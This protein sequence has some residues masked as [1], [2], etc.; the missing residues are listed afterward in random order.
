[1]DLQAIVDT[2]QCICYIAK[3]ATKGEPTSQQATEILQSA[4]NKLFHTDSALS[5]LRRAMIQIAGERD[6]GSY[7]F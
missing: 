3:Y 7:G 5:P 1:M 2:D 4:I 6:I